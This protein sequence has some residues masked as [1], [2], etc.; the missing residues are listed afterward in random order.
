MRYLYLCLLFVV[1]NTLVLFS[2]EKQLTFTEPLSLKTEQLKS[3][4]SNPQLPKESSYPK[5]FE[6]E[7]RFSKLYDKDGPY[8]YINQNAELLDKRDAT[9]KSFMMNDGRVTVISSAGQAHY[10]KDGLWHTILNDIYPSNTYGIYGYACINNSYQT[11]FPNKFN[12]G[13]KVNYENNKS[14]SLVQN[15]GIIYLDENYKELTEKT[16]FTG[17][18]NNVKDNYINYTNLLPG[19]HAKIENLNSKFT[20]DYEIENLSSINWINHLGRKY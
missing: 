6:Q 11:Y 20:L 9:S 8:S 12:D 14:I 7:E 1:S 5:G 19:V 18:V 4:T 16:A 2:Q 17:I 3:L 13:I 15:T 10:K